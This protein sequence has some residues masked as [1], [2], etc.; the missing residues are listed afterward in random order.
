MPVER[1][2]D[3]PCPQFGGARTDLV[4]HRAVPEVNPVVHADRDDRPFVTPCGCRQVRDHFHDAERYLRQTYA[5]RGRPMRTG[6]PV[7]HMQ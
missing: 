3:A 4:D 7:D 6:T 1:D 5:R 2:H